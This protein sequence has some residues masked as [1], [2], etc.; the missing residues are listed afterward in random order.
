MTSWLNIESE[1][2]TMQSGDSAAMKTLDRWHP[3]IIAV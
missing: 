3:S 2:T 1:Y